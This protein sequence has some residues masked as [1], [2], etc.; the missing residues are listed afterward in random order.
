MNFWAMQG[1]AI[2]KDFLK[3]EMIGNLGVRKKRYIG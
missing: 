2:P 3:S 1:L